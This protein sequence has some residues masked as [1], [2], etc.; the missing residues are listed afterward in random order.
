MAQ[1]NGNERGKNVR[2]VDVREQMEV[3]DTLPSRLRELV[4]ALPTKEELLSI[5]MIHRK[6]GDRAREMIEGVFDSEFP[7]W[8][9][10]KPTGQRPG[11]SIRDR[12]ISKRLKGLGTR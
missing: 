5:A 8:R 10:P 4:N 11:Q 6:F 12:R 7:G 1:I 2:V 9:D 3:F